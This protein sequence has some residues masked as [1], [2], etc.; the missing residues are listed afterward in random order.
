MQKHLWFSLKHLAT[1]A[2]Y[3]ISMAV[4][5]GYMVLLTS[6]PMIISKVYVQ[7]QLWFSQKHLATN[8]I[9]VAV[10][11]GYMVLLTSVPMIICNRSSHQQHQGDIKTISNQLAPLKAI[12]EE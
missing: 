10:S 4:S 5:L 7:K 6:V 11:L 8:A 9:S 12:A 3:A 1:N 2:I